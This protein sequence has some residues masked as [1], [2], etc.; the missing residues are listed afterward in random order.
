MF[1]QICASILRWK[2]S[3]IRKMRANVFGALAF[4]ILVLLYRHK[5]K[6]FEESYMFTKV[7]NTTVASV[8][9]MQVTPIQSQV[10][11][12]KNQILSPKIDTKQISDLEM[13]R[14]IAANM[15]NI[16]MK[17]LNNLKTLRLLKEMLNET[18]KC[19][20]EPNLYELKV[21]GN[22]WQEFRVS[23]GTFHLFRLRLHLPCESQK[24]K[25][26][27]HIANFS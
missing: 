27:S 4:M 1:C 17:V 2:T 26:H 6:T 15:E 9:K 5:S 25:R 11:K 19:A 10:S 18:V 20:W 23:N 16:P 14:I 22:L 13:G 12:P 7:E 24:L 3:K 8:L 21:D